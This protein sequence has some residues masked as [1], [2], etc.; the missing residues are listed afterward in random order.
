MIEFIIHYWIQILFGLLISLF[1]YFVKILRNYKKTLDTTNEGVVVILKCK[2]IELFNKLKNQ[3]TITVY[4]KENILDLYNV[5][6]KLE[7][8]DVVD[9]LIKKINNIP[10]G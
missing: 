2:I 7:C 8:C 4:E 1:S 6:K 10:I 3:D 5:Y 9:D